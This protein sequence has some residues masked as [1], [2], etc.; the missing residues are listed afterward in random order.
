MTK[1]ML[2]LVV[3]P[4]GVGKDT[5]LNAARELLAPD[6]RFRFA[7]RVIT[8]AAEAGGEQHDFVTEAEFAAMR[9]A[10]SWQAHGLRY[11]IPIGIVEDIDAGR[12]VVANVSRT[13]IAEAVL[14]FP[15]RVI[16]VAAPMAIL[17]KRLA[18][19]GRE[20]QAQIA[21]RLARLAP[22]PPGIPVERVMNDGTPEQGVERFVAALIR[23]AAVARRSGT[24][25]PHVPA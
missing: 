11:G 17:A 6:P 8:R 5:L 3:G 9:Y 25:G 10:L 15:V 19:R 23:A 16:E 2:V 24:A 1:G 18:G 20:T 21:A 12:V 13:I 22:I 7:R 4:S 14:R